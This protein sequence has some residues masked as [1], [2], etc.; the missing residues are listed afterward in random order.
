[1]GPHKWGDHAHWR[2]GGCYIMNNFRLG[3]QA[4]SSSFQAIGS[5]NCKKNKK[6]VAS[7]VTLR[8]ML[9]A[10]STMDR[11]WLHWAHLLWP[12]LQLDTSENGRTGIDSSSSCPQ[13]SPYWKGKHTWNSSAQYAVKQKEE[14]LLTQMAQSIHL[15]NSCLQIDDLADR[16]IRCYYLEKS[17]ASFACANSI[18]MTGGVIPTYGAAAL[19]STWTFQLGW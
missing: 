8:T 9:A 11:L 3:G 5:D 17:F 19:V 1:M 14:I 2:H 13:D 18:V 6:T 15:D 10:F 7:A 12:C 16:E 4:A